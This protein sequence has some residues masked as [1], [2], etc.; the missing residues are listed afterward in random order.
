VLE[1]KLDTS[2]K[3]KKTLETLPLDNIMPQEH[4]ASTPDYANIEETKVYD[5]FVKEITNKIVTQ[6]Q[7]TSINQTTPIEKQHDVIQTKASET[8][9]ALKTESEEVFNLIPESLVHT[10]NAVAT[11]ETFASNTPANILNNTPHTVQKNS[12]IK[13][14]GAK[15]KTLK[16]MRDFLEYHMQQ[17]H[18][19]KFSK[20]T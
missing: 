13:T 19:N 17:F 9:H 7:N 5:D 6:T 2:P 15:E 1:T 10:D 4:D 20:L 8:S 14:T 11:E 18:S 3:S 12:D 16:E